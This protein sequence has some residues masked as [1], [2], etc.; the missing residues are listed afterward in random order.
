[1][2]RRRSCSTTNTSTNKKIEIVRCQR[3]QKTKTTCRIGF[4]SDT[5]STR[6][7]LMISKFAPEGSVRNAHRPLYQYICSESHPPTVIFQSHFSLSLSLSKNPILLCDIDFDFD[8]WAMTDGHLFNN[9]SLGGRGGT[10]S[11]LS[12]SLS[13]SLS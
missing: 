10:V 6:P 11:S 1:M 2:K 9:I 3:L 12:L 5:K 13:L 4:S 8:F 7:Q